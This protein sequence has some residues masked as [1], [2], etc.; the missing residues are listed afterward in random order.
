MS[1]NE[2]IFAPASGRG[3]AGVAVIRISGPAAAASLARLTGVTDPVP[4]RAIRVRIRDEEGET[5][6]RGLALWFAGPASFTGEDVAELHVHGGRAV[7]EGVLE[8]LAAAPG[9]RP[10][11]PGEFTRRAFE[12]DKLDLT[13]AEGIADLVNAETRAQRRQ[14]VRQME[15]ALGR[16][17]DGWRLRL[18]R[19]LAH[20]EALIDFADEELPAE[21]EERVRVEVAAL[22]EEILRHLADNRRGERLRDGIR[23]A[24]VGPPNAGKSSLLN[25]LARR[26]AAIIASSPGTT[27]DVIEVHL[28]LAGYPVVLADTAGLREAAEAVER[29]GVRRSLCAAQQAD[30]KIA[31][32]DG[33]ALPRIDEKTAALLD[34]DSLVVLNKSDIARPARPVVVNGRRA[35][36]ISARTGAGMSAL[37]VRL[38]EEVTRRWRPGQ[39]PTLTRVR[40]RQAL[41]R[42]AAALKRVT[43]VGDAAGSGTAMEP[44]A[45]ELDAMEPDIMDLEMELVAEDLRLAIRE[46]GRI[47]GR[48]DV[49]DI[50]DV[51]FRDFCIGK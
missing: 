27:R 36:A 6:D 40:H 7:V 15:G 18:I 24:I 25:V 51:I 48:V 26:D 11:E 21:I 1:M 38:E 14:A 47:T 20:Q 32:F 10:A 46:L 42:C 31:V 4:R 44:E 5:I 8:A 13:A 3:A 16:L 37:L 23:I 41:E 35:I 12:N 17:Y 2:T 19:L 49:E 50:L 30:L 34:D 9:L 28:D 22:A 45:M 43:G 29:E 39:G 33:A